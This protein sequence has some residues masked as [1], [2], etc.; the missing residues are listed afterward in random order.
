M[1]VPQFA[2]ADN[3]D[4][5]ADSVEWCPIPQLTQFLVCGTYHLDEGQ[6][7]AD[8]TQIRNGNITSYKLLSDPELKLE[9]ADVVD[10][11]GVLDMKWY[12]KSLNEAA[13]LGVA[14]SSGKVLL[15]KVSVD[16]DTGCLQPFAVVDC[17]V[18]EKKM[19]LSLDWANQEDGS[20]TLITSDTLGNLNYFCLRDGELCLTESWKA[21]SFEA[22]ISAFDYSQPHIVYSGGDDCCFK[23][24]DLRNTSNTVFVNK[25]HS[26]G[27]TSISKSKLNE[28][29]LVTGSYDEHV[30]LWDVRK[31]KTP[32]SEIS[33]GG[34]IWRL[35][36]HPSNPQYLLT[37]SMH[38]GFHAVSIS[39]ETLTLKGH[40]TKHDSLAYGVDWCCQSV[41]QNEDENLSYS[42]NVVASCSFYDKLLNLWT[43]NL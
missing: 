4:F 30:F 24:W 33:L 40:Y 5:N 37:A 38:N 29:L 35:K 23:C 2:F 8:G 12:P 28:H 11:G 15:L 32:I 6:S 41:A 18:D 16:E 36:W 10:T 27:V 17:S 21:H 13:V 34:G 7:G 3:T 31:M 1:E 14:C 9:K 25:R 42:P 19:M 22:W 39:D 26:M 43:I 20:P